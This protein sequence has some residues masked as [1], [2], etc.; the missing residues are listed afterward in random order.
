MKY[1]KHM[2]YYNKDK[3]EVPSA[4]TILKILNKPFLAKWANFMGFKRKRIQDIL[5]ETS[6]IGTMLHKLIEVYTNNKIFVFVGGQYSS[7]FLMIQFM[8][9]FLEWRKLHE[10]EP[11]FTEHHMASDQYGGTVD[12]YGKVDGKCTILDYKTSKRFYPGMFLQLG[13][14]CHMLEEQGYKVEQVA[15]IRVNQN[16]YKEKFMTREQLTPYINTFMTLVS[17]FHMWYKL[18]IEEGWGDILG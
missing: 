4:T 11:I 12:F 9:S 1:S 16:E 18:N 7:R 17:L 2:T 14:Y 5:D 8:N 10:V 13:A 3:I 6:E 15:I